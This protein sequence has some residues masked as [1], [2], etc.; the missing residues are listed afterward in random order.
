MLECKY[1]FEIY[2]VCSQGHTHTY[3]HIHTNTHI[4]HIHIYT[5]T[6]L[7]HIHT[8]LLAKFSQVISEN[9][10]TLAANCA[11]RSVNEKWPGYLALAISSNL[12]IATMHIMGRG[13]GGG[14]GGASEPVS[15][16]RG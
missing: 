15:E 7:P 2:A 12:R 1:E 14:G 8:Y 16:G 10:C 3:T 9:T 11:R 4:T 6:H 13:G 5:Y